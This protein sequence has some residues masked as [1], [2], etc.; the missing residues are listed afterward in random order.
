MD[1]GKALQP[2]PPSP[3]YDFNIRA[4]VQLL[5]SHILALVAVRNVCCVGQEG[6]GLQSCGVF[7]KLYEYA[8]FKCV[9]IDVQAF[10]YQRDA[11]LYCRREV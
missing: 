9:Q 8:C 4:R 6:L 7:F 2:A 5:I 1:D 11:E 3:L 10:V